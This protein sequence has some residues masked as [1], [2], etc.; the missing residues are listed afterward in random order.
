M[1]I[2]PPQFCVA[3]PSL[4]LASMHQ[5]L[6]ILHG[7]VFPKGLAV[8]VFSR[9]SLLEYARTFCAILSARLC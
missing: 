5:N 7:D 6:N 8:F 1:G 2:L 3:I 9:M 4:M